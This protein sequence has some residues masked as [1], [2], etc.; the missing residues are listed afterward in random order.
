[1]IHIASR[2][3]KS[4]LQKITE[5]DIQPNAVDLR[6]G[7]VWKMH[8]PFLIDEENKRHRGKLEMSL[9]LDGYY[10]FLPGHAYEISFD[11]TVSMGEGEAGFVIPRSTLNR[12]GLFI[13][14][15]LYD[16]GYVGTLAACLHISGSDRAYIKPG[17]RIAQFLL[18]NAEALHSYDGDYGLAAD[19]S[20]KEMEKQYVS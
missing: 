18:F 16:S 10:E 6:L 11:N 3:T 14:S 4:F 17:T 9:N 20:A 13:T 19:G 12:N 8:G 5:D 15:G 1:M 7:K 2:V